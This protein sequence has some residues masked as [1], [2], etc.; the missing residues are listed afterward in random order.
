M[1]KKKRFYGNAGRNQKWT[2]EE[3][4]RPID[5]ADKYIYS[6]GYSDKY[7]YLRPK[8]KPKK[9]TKEIAAKH[10]KRLGALLCA[11]LILG[12]G[13]TAM[14]VYMIR[15]GIPPVRDAQAD[16]PDKDFSSITLN[17]QGEYIDSVSL[18]GGVMLKAV[19]DNAVNGSF[20]S[21][22]FDIK[23]S[24]GSV[25]YKSSLAAV[26]TY[27]AV[28][29]PASNLKA[30][31][32]ALKSSDL[33]CA[34]IV[35]CY[36][37][38][39]VPEQNRELALYGTTGAIYRDSKDNTYL[40]P[41]K[42]GTYNYIRDIIS[43]TNEMGITIFILDGFE[44]PE[45]I[46]SEY[47]DGFEALSKRLYQDIGT[48]IKLLKA[49]HVHISRDLIESEDADEDIIKKFSSDEQDIIYLVSAAAEEET[50]KEKLEECGISNYILTQ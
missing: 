15:T 18:D 5:F 26:D 37:D 11:L 48:S 19:A 41:N 35:N 9:N 32:D 36:L 50:I 38:N 16:R 44:L 12:A 21:V 20:N 47:N 23:R 31:T 40:N 33:L 30:S 14:D 39:L 1:K 2:E 34:G 27:G 49:K 6:E 46:S 7:D 3:Q 10:L 25:G 24:E 28:A 42:E 13:Y 17:L 45:E 29:F 43:E 4:G 22:V 8:R